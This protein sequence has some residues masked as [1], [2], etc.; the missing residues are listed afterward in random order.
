MNSVILFIEQF[1]N[2][3]DDAGAKVIYRWDWNYGAKDV[4]VSSALKKSL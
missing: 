4:S 2:S 3:Y 1:L